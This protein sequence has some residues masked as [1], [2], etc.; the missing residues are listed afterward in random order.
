MNLGSQILLSLL[1]NGGDNILGECL[2]NIL[3]VVVDGNLR[4]TKVLDVLEHVDWVCQ[5]H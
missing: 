5:S 1:A 4:C 2:K 3:F